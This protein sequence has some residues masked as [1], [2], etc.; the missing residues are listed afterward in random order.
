MAVQEM[1]VIKLGYDF[2]KWLLQHTGKFPKSYRFSVAAK[3][4]NTPPDNM[5]QRIAS[6]VGHAKQADTDSLLKSLF[7]PMVGKPASAEKAAKQS[8]TAHLTL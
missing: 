1:L 6:W 7:Q 8:T 2:S 4:E 3:M 5:Q